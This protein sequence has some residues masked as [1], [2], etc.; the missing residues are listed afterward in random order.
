MNITLLLPVHIAV[1][2]VFIYKMKWF[3][4]PFLSKITLMLIFILK[5]AAGLFAGYYYSMKYGGGDT[6]AFFKD[7]IELKSCL[8]HH[9]SH[10][11]TYLKGDMA[12]SVFYTKCGTLSAWIN[13]DPLY[14]DNHTVTLLHMLLAFISGE[15]YPVHVAWFAF[16]SLAGLMGIYRLFRI[17]A[18]VKGWPVILTLF[19]LPSILFWISVASKESLAIFGT[20][21]FCGTA[22]LLHSGQTSWL[23]KL[24]CVLSFCMALLIKIYFVILLL[25][26]L[27]AF[28]ISKGK[29]QSVT[30]KNYVL[31]YGG[32]FVLLLL[33]SIIIPPADVC[34]LI[35][36]KRQSFEVYATTFPDGFTTYLQLPQFENNWLS[37]LLHTPAAAGV[38]LLQPFEFSKD[39]LPLM[40]LSIENL[41]YVAIVFIAILWGKKRIPRQLN[42]ILFCVLFTYTLLA[43]IGLTTPVAGAIIRYKSIILPFLMMIPVILFVNP[44]SPEAIDKKA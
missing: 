40:F 6:M 5:I 24:A 27:F 28:I 32:G 21:V 16:F 41:F 4:D 19:A 22:A 1:L 44:G 20:G 13:D 17:I 37:L 15:S 7:G 26:A 38:S 14:N 12:S 3:D 23:N 10:F 25:P 34:S 35:Y 2:C 39:Q 43:L 11:I 36:N 30:L 8:M 18:Q 9:F 29:S 31:V 33:L 42:A